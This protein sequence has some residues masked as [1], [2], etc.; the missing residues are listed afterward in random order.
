LGRRGF[1]DPL[2]LLE[3]HLGGGSIL[4]SLDRLGALAEHG[5]ECLQCHK[6]MKIVAIVDD[7]GL[8]EATLCRM[9]KRQELAPR[10]PTIDLHP[11]PVPETEREKRW[12]DLPGED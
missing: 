4:M 2:G 5:L 12:D 8:V 3:S 10:G 9:G 11:P 6:P 1:L 7:A